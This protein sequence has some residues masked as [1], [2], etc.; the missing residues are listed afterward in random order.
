MKERKNE[1][2]VKEGTSGGEG[3]VVASIVDD[4]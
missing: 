1:R 2:V 3:V 4:E